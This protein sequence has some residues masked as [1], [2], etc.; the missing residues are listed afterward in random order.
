MRFLMW[1]RAAQTL[2]N[3]LQLLCHYPSQSQPGLSST[4][5]PLVLTKY[6]MTYHACPNWNTPSFLFFSITI[7]NYVDTLPC[8]A[9]ECNMLCTVGI[10]LTEGLNSGQI[11]DLYL[12]FH[13]WQQILCSCLREASRFSFFVIPCNSL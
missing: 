5:C 13:C 11:M 9:E 12:Y 6:N 8:E 7:C 1:N 4:N 3:D 10:F 2:K